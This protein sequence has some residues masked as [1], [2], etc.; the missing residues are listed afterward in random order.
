MPAW[1]ALAAAAFLNALLALDLPA[2]EGSGVSWLRASPDGL[3]LLAAAGLSAAVPRRWNRP[4][5]PALAGAALGLRLFRTADLFVPLVFSRPF[6]LYLDLPR[7][8]DLLANF[9]QTSPPTALAAAALGAAAALA[10]LGWGVWRALAV[11]HRAAG[12]SR[13]ARGALLAFGAAL[14]LAIAAERLAPAAFPFAAPAILP[15]VAEEARFIL[16]LDRTRLRHREAIAVAVRSTDEAPC[17]LKRLSG[18]SVFIFVIE[19]YGEVALT[20]PRFT[21]RVLPAAEA[22]ERSL[23]E[24]GFLVA[25]GALS[26]PT[27]G[28]SS[29]LAH[30][31]LDSGVRLECQ[32]RYAL[33]FDSGAPTLAAIYRRA[34]YRTVRAMPGTLTPWPAG[35]F[36]RYHATYIAPD[37]G[38]RGPEFSWN[39]VPDQFVLDWID[40]REIRPAAGPLLVEF[41]LGDSHAPWD[42]LP[43]RITPWERI[44]D[45]RVFL[46]APP[47]RFP[48]SWTALAAATDAYGALIAHEIELVSEFIRR[49]LPEGALAVIVGDHAP[50]R[51]LLGEGASRSVPVHI[52]SRRA[53]LLAPFLAAGFRSGMIPGAG[54]PRA[55]L[56]AL[57]RLLTAG[58]SLGRGEGEIDPPPSPREALWASSR[59]STTAAT[60]SSPSP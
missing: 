36:F 24:A 30:A 52:A 51:E 33:L 42:V 15:R 57:F 19:S 32:L 34:G 54:E 3:L 26:S 35:D 14:G 45:G 11:V 60:P 58:M 4:L 7:L 31:T 18:A 55:G 48:T 37:F 41:I 28:G 49:A 46:E 40:R 17:D 22:A 25:A 10:A 47:V 13:A 23:R 2:V 38:Y 21:G 8:P 59:S 29:W 1:K 16:D 20:D 27:F 44:G 6:N 5:I 50:C 39:P 9:R 56:E 12:R 43:P 53:D